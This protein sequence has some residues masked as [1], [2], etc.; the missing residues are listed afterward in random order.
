MPKE[1]DAELS[2]KLLN[3]YM[4]SL[5]DNPQNHDKVEFEIIFSCFT[6]DLDTRLE[7]LYEHGFT[8]PELKQ[9]SLCLKDLTNDIVCTENGLL[10][11]D[12]SK[13][14]E[15]EARRSELLASSIDKVSKIYWLL[16]DCNA[17]V[18]CHSPGWQEGAS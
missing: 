8:K 9:L 6:F 10:Q 2:E 17:M 14:N 11:N 7:I 5:I 18:R 1:L 4:Q 13:I 12:L 15:L 3:Y 16:E